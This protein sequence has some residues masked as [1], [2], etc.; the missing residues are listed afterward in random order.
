MMFT[1][2]SRVC[3]IDEVSSGLD[4]LSRR[5]I[6][7]ILLAERSSRTMLLT[8]HF[9]D[10]A[11]VL[12][13]HIVLMSKGN[14]TAEGSAPEL[15]HRY[16]DGYQV[17]VPSSIQFAIPEQFEKIPRHTSYDETIFKLK[18][19]AHAADFIQELEQAGIHDYLI[20]GST[21]ED[22]FLKLAQ[23]AQGDPSITELKAKPDGKDLDGAASMES[24]ERE[25]DASSMAM[26]TS[27]GTSMPRQTWILFKK[28][29]TILRRSYISYGAAIIIPIITAGL[30]TLFLKNFTALSCSPG[31]QA[32]HPSVNSL[33]TY[34]EVLMV[35]GPSSRIS[36]QQLALV[37]GLD[38]SNFHI[39]DSLSAF[40]DFISANYA[41]VAPGG[42]FVGSSPSDT[43][44]FAYVGNYDI[45]P[46]VLTQNIFDNVLAGIPIATQYQSFATPFAAG[47]GKSLQVIFYFG[48]AMSAY[49]AFFA[50]YPTMERLRKVRALHYSNGIR[51]LPLWMAYLVFDFMFVLVVSA[52]TTGIFVGASNIWY[53][54]EY[55]FVVFFLY[56]VASILVSYVISLFVKSQLAAFA[57]AAGGQAAMFLLYFVT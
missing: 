21:I 38:T 13:D 8:T 3:C 22:V 43:P 24:S 57:F 40:N 15:K 25:L 49:P 34:D 42:F 45:D 26:S 30:V 31:A 19:S 47:A 41:D 5:K 52:V 54:P 48:L 33:S 4:P 23:E 1:G 55:L 9:L 16:G 46:A 35:A 2:G 39:V 10:E 20:G 44:V 36:A 17:S 6:W 7:D 18:D 11:D 37:S 32:S 14:L 50:L 28:R 29:V 51:A 27:Q 56:G 12:S 53:H